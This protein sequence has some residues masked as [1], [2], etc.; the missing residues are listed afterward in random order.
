[1]SIKNAENKITR[2]LACGWVHGNGQYGPG[3]YM[4]LSKADRRA[5][6]RNRR[7]EAANNAWKPVAIATEV[8]Q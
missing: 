3:R 8:A 6:I 7:A 1:V 4:K 2:A 5:F